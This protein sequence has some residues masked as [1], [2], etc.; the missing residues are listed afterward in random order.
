LHFDRIY[1]QGNFHESITL[2]GAALLHGS[3]DSFGGG[4]VKL[5]EEFLVVHPLVREESREAR[6]GL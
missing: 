5:I 6:D 4:H 1:R 2:S 3:I